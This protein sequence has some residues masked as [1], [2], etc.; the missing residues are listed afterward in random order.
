MKPE[1]GETLGQNLRAS[2]RILGKHYPHVQKR[3]L[4]SQG[5]GC[6]IFWVFQGPSAP[7]WLF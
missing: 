6:R 7:V 3:G 1:T 2:V 4:R 5:M